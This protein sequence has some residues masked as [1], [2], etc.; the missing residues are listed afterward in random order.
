MLFRSAKN[1]N[2]G[3]NT[4]RFN[5]CLNQ[6]SSYAGAIGLPQFM[7]S[8]IRSFAVDGDGDG[9]IDLRQSPKDA[10]ASVANFMKKHGWQAGMPISFPVQENG[11]HKIHGPDPPPENQ[12]S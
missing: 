11:Q 10:I 8:S 9:R 1:S 7:P 2:Q 12:K 5:A 6:N 4:I 3:V